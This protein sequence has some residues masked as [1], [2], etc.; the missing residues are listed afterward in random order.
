MHFIFH[1]SVALLSTATFASASNDLSR[2]E[3][4]RAMKS[5]VSKVREEQIWPSRPQQAMNQDDVALDT[6]YHTIIFPHINPLSSSVVTQ[7]TYKYVNAVLSTLIPAS[8]LQEAK[9]DPDAYAR[10]PLPERPWY[11]ALPADVKEYI[12]VV[13][14]A[15]RKMK[16]SQDVMNKRAHL[17]PRRLR[18]SAW[19]WTL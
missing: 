12:A 9:A 11:K 13:S 16:A 15:D 19:W 7:G 10:T 2:P 6:S 3:I 8:E 4:D 17:E 5:L 14:E 1:F 18:G